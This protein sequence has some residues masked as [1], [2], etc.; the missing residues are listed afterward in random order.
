[1]AKMIIDFDESKNELKREVER[2]E[3]LKR[4]I[5]IHDL[6]ASWESFL[7]AKLHDSYTLEVKKK[8]PKL[9]DIS[10]L[11]SDFI[12]DHLVYE[13]WQSTLQDM[14]PVALEPK[15]LGIGQSGIIMQKYYDLDG[16]FL[17]IPFP[18]QFK[19]GLQLNKEYEFLQRLIDSSGY[20]PKHFPYLRADRCILKGENI[21]A[22]AMETDFG[23]TMAQYVDMG[24]K[25][26]ESDIIR[27]G[28]DILLGLMEMREAGILYH[29]DV[30]PRNILITDALREEGITCYIFGAARLLDMEYATTNSN[31]PQRKY[32][33]RR[34]SGPNDLASLGENLFYVATGT[35]VFAERKKHNKE[36]SDIA[37]EIAGNR[38]KAYGAEGVI[39]KK[40]LGKVDRMIKYEKAASLIKNLLT[41]KKDDHEKIMKM[42]Q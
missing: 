19:L 26:E 1:M 39:D 22:L 6:E 30:H 8:L 31:A 15:V 28:K 10:S 9:K 18:L 4:G 41:A 38:S 25:W 32:G 5:T 14:P 33:N 40:Y 17:L 13:N 2:V 23:F 12:R 24:L 21:V 11:A 3:R 7:K 27:I 36:L 34:F 42:I 37:N 16:K 35:S 29:R 20:K